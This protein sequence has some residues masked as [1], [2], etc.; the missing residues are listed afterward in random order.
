MREWRW[1]VP[2]V[3]RW[4]QGRATL[5]GCCRLES[6][7]PGLLGLLLLLLVVVVVAARGRTNGSTHPPGIPGKGPTHRPNERASDNLKGSRRE[8]LAVEIP[9]P[10]P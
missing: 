10:W 2:K 1:C 5:K 4:V 8:E 6:A 3:G 9:A 7:L